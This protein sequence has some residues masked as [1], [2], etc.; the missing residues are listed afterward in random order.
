MWAG[1][2]D[3]DHLYAIDPRT[4]SV[5]AEVAAPGKPYGLTAIGNELRAVVS[6]GEDDDRFLYRCVPGQ[7]F[8]LD[9]KLPCP[10][11][12]GSHLASD[13][14]QLYLAQLGKRRILTL[15]ER[16]S[17]VREIPVPTRFGGMGFGAGAFYI[18]AADDEFDHLQ[19]ATLDVRV[20]RPEAVPV[21]D[22]S[23]EARALAFDGTNWWTSY[24]EV[25]EIVSFVI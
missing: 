7:G 20:D 10:D 21:A 2:W 14:K 16:G 15:D 18:I 19:F 6:I 23:P 22:V 4:W 12:T 5:T 13:G 11:L 17:V 8:D 3:T 24:R 9:S 1:C 25:N